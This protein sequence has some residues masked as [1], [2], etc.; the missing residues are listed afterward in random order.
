MAAPSALAFLLLPA[1]ASA[2]PRFAFDDGRKSLE[3]AQAYQVWGAATPDPGNVPVPDPRAD[4][5]LRRARLGLRG[6]AQPGLDYLVWFAYDNAGKDPLTGSLGSPQPMA[7]TTFQVWDAYFTWRADSAWVNLTFGLFRPQAGREF[8]SSFAS[9]PSLEKA[10]THYYLRDH[11]HTRPSGRETGMNLGGFR[12]DTARGWAFGY[13]FGIFDAAQERTSGAAAGSVS[14]SPLLTGRL[15]ATLGDPEAKDYRLAVDHNAFGKRRGATL[16]A[17]ATWQGAVGERVDT[18]QANPYA[19]GF[20][21]NASMGADLL[22]N[23]GG[24]ELDAEADILWRRFS[25]GFPA[26]Y[27]SVGKNPA[28]RPDRESLELA[29][30]ARGGYSFAL[31]GGRYLEPTVAYSRFAGD[32]HSPVNTGGEDR[33]LDAGINGYLQKN[34]LKVSLHYLW[35]EGEARSLF[36]QG[37]NARGELRQR[38]DY[39]ALGVLLAL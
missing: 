35:Q 1:L 6:Q 18:A 36:T 5:Y 26:R 34:A 33:V 25:E 2:G 7:N 31:P 19:G 9:V 10:L 29:W 14:W 28:Y 21:A 27:A 4:L 3:I 16:G 13:N 8:I 11:L 20:D 22:C 39:L 23:W 32:V 12:A 17:F 37:P 38:N 24:L 15:T 30:H